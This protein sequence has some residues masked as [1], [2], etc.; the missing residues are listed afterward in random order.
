MLLTGIL[1]EFLFNCNIN[2]IKK[3]LIGSF[4]VI[5]ELLLVSGFITVF[6]QDIAIKLEV[7]YHLFNHIICL[8]DSI[9]I[10]KFSQVVRCLRII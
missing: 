4:L 8:K 9:F 1:S 2:F 6:E 5:P 7:E 10:G 3:A